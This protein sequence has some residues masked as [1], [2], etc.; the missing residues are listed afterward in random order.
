MN[1][2]SNS[3]INRSAIFTQTVASIVHAQNI[4]CSKT[5]IC[6]HFAGHMVHS[7]T[8]KTKE[9][10]LNDYTEY[11]YLTSKQKQDVALVKRSGYYFSIHDPAVMSTL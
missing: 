9:N 3:S 2:L 10:T 8:M 5:H 11:A 7:W 1:P 4:I 6:R